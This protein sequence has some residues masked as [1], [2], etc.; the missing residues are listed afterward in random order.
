MGQASYK[1]VKVTDGWGIEHDGKVTGSYATKEV[2]FEA[3]IGPASNAIKEGHSVQISIAGSAP[4][5]P[6]LGYS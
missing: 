5:E 2:A 6:A 3:A 4:N 1:V